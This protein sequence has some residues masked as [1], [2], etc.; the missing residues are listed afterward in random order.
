[1]TISRVDIA[2]ADVQT[3]LNALLEECESQLEKD[4]LYRIRNE[5]LP[6]PTEAQKLIYDG[7]EPI[8]R[9]DFF[10]EESNL[11]VFVDGPVH[12][13]DYVSADDSRK[14]DR[15][16][17]LGY[18]VIGLTGPEEIDPLRDYLRT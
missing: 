2:S 17:S 3:H 12:E 9:P 7:D 16:R 11:C 14:R 15:L 6:L 8:A 4:T 13:R 1:M 10:Y 5:Q 18:R